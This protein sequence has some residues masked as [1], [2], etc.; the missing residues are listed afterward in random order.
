MY[1]SI[2]I[3]NSINSIYVISFW[4]L[5]SSADSNFILTNAFVCMLEDLL[6]WLM[7]NILSVY[8]YMC[9]H[10]PC[11]PGPAGHCGAF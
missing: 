11:Q 4:S 6:V 2:G 8:L 5:V 7:C 9:A 1:N 10:V 3:N